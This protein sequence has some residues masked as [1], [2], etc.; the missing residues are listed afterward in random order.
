MISPETTAAWAEAERLARISPRRARSRWRRRSCSRRTCCSTSMARTSARGPTSPGPAAGRDDA[1]AGLHRAAGADAHGLAAARPRATPMRARCSAGRS[2]ERRTAPPNTCRSGYE[3][4][5]GD[6]PA[7]GDARCSP[8]SGRAGRA[9][10]RAAD[11]R[12][13]ARDRGHSGADASPARKAALLRH[14]WRPAALCGRCSTGSAAVAP[15]PPTRAALLAAADPFA[16]AGP[17][18]GLRSRDEIAARIAAL[19]ADAAEPPIPRPSGRRSTGFWRSRRRRPEALERLRRCPAARHR[20]AADRAMAGGWTRWRRGASTSG[21]LTFRASSGW[22]ALEYYD[23]FVF[24]FFDPGSTQDGRRPGAGHRRPLRCADRGAGRA[25][26]LGGG[27]G[28]PA[29]PRGR[30]EGARDDPAW[31]F[32]PRAG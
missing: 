5:G 12:L 23:G 31:A 15:V 22:T 13:G 14:I 1:A 27:R 3:L 8:P 29:R 9:G 4:F 25:P 11:R 6:D 19:R 30:R 28:G 26:G 10:A 21:A 17:E 20:A 24:G 32:R 7:A 18:I 2:S 16:G